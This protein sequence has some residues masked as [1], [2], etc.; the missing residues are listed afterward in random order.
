MNV[1][2]LSWLI[3]AS[4]I[5]SSVPIF[6]KFYIETHDFYWIIFSLVFYIF[7]ILAYYKILLNGKS[8]KISKYYTLI[9]ILSILLIFLMG[10]FLFK[11]KITI[12]T[13]LAILLAFIAIYLLQ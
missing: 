3:L 8:K 4:L 1:Y 6:V 13:L 11:E 10:L 7:L 2:I 5:A 9:K 12:K